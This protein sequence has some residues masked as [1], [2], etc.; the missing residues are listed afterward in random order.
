MY[1]LYQLGMVVHKG[2]ESGA[3]ARLTQEKSKFKSS[4]TIVTT[5]LKIK[6]NNEKPHQRCHIKTFNSRCDKW[7]CSTGSGGF[8]QQQPGKALWKVSCKWAL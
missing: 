6:P 3:L 5:C 8:Q 2:L 4:L 7:N 1:K